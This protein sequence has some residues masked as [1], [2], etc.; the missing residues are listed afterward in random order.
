MQRAFLTVCILLFIL[1]ACAAT[2]DEQRPLEAESLWHWTWAG[3]ARLDPEGERLV[4]VRT[5]VDRAADRYRSNLWIKDLSTGRHRALTTHEAGA[6]SP[7]WSPDGQSIAFLSSRR[8]G[9]QIWLLDLSGGE[10]RQLTALEGGAGTPVWSPQGDRIAFLSRALTAEEREARREEERQRRAAEREARGLDSD[11]AMERAPAPVV[12]ESLRYQAD[13]RSDYLPDERRHIWLVD[14]DPE[15]EWPASP[16]RI[17]QGDWDFGTPAWS[18]DGDALFFS[19]LL[20][21]DADWRFGESHIY[22]LTI[23]AGAGDVEQLTEGRRNRGTPMVSPDGRWLAFTGNE[24]REPGL[25][26]SLS[27][28]YVMPLEGGEERKLSGDYDRSVADGTSGDMASPA[29]TGRRIQWAPDSES[30]WFTTAKDG[31]TQLARAEREGGVHLLTDYP[32]G[33]LQAFS[34]AG[35][36]IALLWGNPE[37]PFDLYLAGSDSLPERERWDRLTALN[38]ALLQGRRFAPYEEVWYESFDGKDIQGWVIR[39]DDFDPR[40]SYPAILYIHGGPHA[41]YGTTFFHEFQTLADAGYV[42]LITNPRGSSGYGQDFGNIIQYRYPGHDYKD[43]MAGVDW[44]LEQGYV[45]ADRLG[46]TG[47]SGGGLL[48]AWTVTQTDRFAAAAAQRSVMNWHSF[49]GTADM[50]L[51]FVER[52]FPAP[53]WEDPMHYIQRSPLAHVDRV[54]TPMLL[55]HSEEDWRTPLEQTQQFY[56]QLRMQGKTARLVI[57]PEA[58]HGLSRGGRPSQ[59]IE[60]LNHIRE[61]FDDH[62]MNQ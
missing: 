13:G 39:P 35:E 37:Q 43:L 19:G 7:R 55:I 34:L 8:D 53:P 4:Y 38:D 60:R 57:F 47:G 6:R 41:M 3:D 59:R 61:W 40:R 14:V 44:L 42:V 48:T 49:V 17:T 45:D 10:A 62:L 27:E 26:Y 15:A 32:A 28:L 1:P 12:I 18:A 11:A 21:E 31:Q 56:A 25:S 20:E 23:D 5:E 33:D 51:F 30:L 54:D 2:P 16:R 36:R 24:H 52:W 29:G 50:N 9:N 58:S 22:R 46:V